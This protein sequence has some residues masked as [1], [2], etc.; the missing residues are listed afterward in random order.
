MKKERGKLVRR[1]CAAVARA[2]EE[3]WAFARADRRNPVFAAKVGLAL[4]LVSLLAF[5][6]E[7]RDAAGHTVWAVL[8]VVVIFEFNI[9]THA[10][11]PALL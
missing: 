6:R 9:G 8:T 7:P 1:A 3:M 11:S 5:L 2:A 10:P 4:A